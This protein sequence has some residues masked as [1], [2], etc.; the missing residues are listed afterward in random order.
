M[1]YAAAAALLGFH[2]LSPA[3]AAP[4][5]I[6]CQ[7]RNN[8]TEKRLLECIRAPALWGHLKAL[9]QIADENPGRF[10]HG[11]R[12]TGTPGYRASVS[13][14]AHLLRDAGYRV[15]IQSYPWRRSKL[16]ERPKFALDGRS[17]AQGE[18]WFVASLSGSGAVHGF[19]QALGQPDMESE[20]GCSPTDFK[21]FIPGRIALLPRG[22]C[23]FDAQ[24]ADATR[25]GASAVILYNNRPSDTAAVYR[26]H[27]NGEAFPA[28]LTVD[29][30][31]P[32]L[33]M[34]SHD[35]GALLAARCRSGGHPR[36]D[37]D[38]HLQRKSDTDY[39][40][41][42]DSPFGDPERTVV[43]DAHLDSIYG[44]GILDNG[45]G[46]ATVL[47][48]A[49]NMAHT[50]TKNH[51]RYIWF[52][53]E[54]IALLGSRYYTKTL[55]KAELKKIAFDIDVDVTATPN[56]AVLV[57]DPG[58]AHAR[59]KFPP[60]V[61]P[62]S[63]IGN[64]Y[65]AA[66]FRKIG[67]ASRIASFGNDGTDSLSFSLA[68]V[69][70]SGILTQQNCCKHD[71]EVR[72]WG[73][74]PGNFEG[75]IPGYNGGCVDW[76]RRWCD[77]LSNNSRVVLEFVSKAVAHVVFKLANNPDLGRGSAGSAAAVPR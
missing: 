7:T 1:C 36:V 32:V 2:P 19:P 59:D 72:L 67:I 38:V 73:G 31:I 15:Q 4:S 65:F 60:N 77:N 76:P 69:P 40:V 3:A 23:D 48:L 62:E 17:Y 28:P 11:N 53:G 70:N 43:V 52:G 47:E 26:R 5:S 46:S 34:L 39:N 21:H 44:A 20:S 14:V 49:L 16:L 63:Q 10:G 74:F 24:V 41:I 25:A 50:P 13:Y 33:G 75:K 58:H 35:L 55:P 30:R 27:G 9:Q 12:D 22:V 71:W 37:I 51:L 18:G 6:D 57:A 54:E 64:R 61:I 45:S 42:A 66:Y 68:G 56:Y 8:D 29:A